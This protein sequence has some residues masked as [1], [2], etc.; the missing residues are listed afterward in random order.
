MLTIKMGDCNFMSIWLY[1]Y[2]Y[3]SYRTK[4]IIQPVIYG[5]A[6]V[7]MLLKLVRNIELHHL[8]TMYLA[9]AG[10]LS[11]EDAP[12]RGPSSKLLPIG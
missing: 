11:R 5:T 7:L 8:L 12:G 9:K 6:D 1:V 10:G 4:L 2:M 3:L